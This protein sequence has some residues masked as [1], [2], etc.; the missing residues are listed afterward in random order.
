MTEIDVWVMAVRLPQTE[1]ALLRHLRIRLTC[2][3][4]MF[5]YTHFHLKM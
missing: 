3:R 5:R 4:Q 2:F 1:F